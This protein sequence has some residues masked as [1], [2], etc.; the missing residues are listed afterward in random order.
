M[1][2][3]IWFSNCIL[4][5]R[6][7]RA[8]GSWLYSMSELLCETGKVCLTNIA[9][10]K[11]SNAIEHTV[12]NDLFDEFT[13]PDWRLCQ[14]GLP[15]LENCEK[16]ENVCKEITPDIIHVWG[17]ENYFCHLVPSF[18]TNAKVLL[19]I[20]G[21]RNKCA[22]VYY[23]DL[24]AEETLK[25]LGVREIF[26]PFISIYSQ[27]RS[28]RKEGLKDLNVLK[29]Y[30]YISTQSEWVRAQLMGQTNAHLYKTRMSIRKDFLEAGKWTV[31]TK[32]EISL[33]WCSSTLFPYKSLQTAIKALGVLKNEYPAIKLFIVGNIKPKRKHFVNGY[34]KYIDQLINKL[35]LLDNVVYTGSL[36]PKEMIKMMRECM[37]S[38]QTSYVE[39]YSLALAEAMAIG[40]PS[41]IS[42]AGAMPELVE[43]NVSGLFFS[44]GDYQ[45]CAYNIRKLIENKSLAEKISGNAYNRTREVS[46]EIIVRETQLEIYKDILTR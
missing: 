3:I 33:L 27:K 42:Y 2:R 24:T 38:I 17:V 14:N 32:E 44:P 7:N 13:I 18:K 39:S 43:N 25:C 30:N 16:I 19:E 28:F 22:D 23:G 34:Y 35:G 37:C 12:I 20:Q 31:P 11:Q 5:K 1:I 46:S 41:V 8:S 4:S 45:S 6:Q 21:L 40:L 10:C 9:V 15:C 29:K 36:Y 26:F